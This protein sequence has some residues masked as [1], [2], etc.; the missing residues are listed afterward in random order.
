ML[1]RDRITGA[2]R[3]VVEVTARVGDMRLAYQ[4]FHAQAAPWTEMLRHESR[5][6]RRFVA[7]RPFAEPKAA[8]GLVRAA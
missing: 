1:A 7:T 6:A 8:R 3:V 4:R 2:A 5:G